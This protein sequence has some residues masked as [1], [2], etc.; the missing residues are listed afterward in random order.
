[1]LW[2]MRIAYLP[3]LASSSTGFVF[4]I[5]YCHCVVMKQN[6]D[7]FRFST[8]SFVVSTWNNSIIHTL[9]LFPWHNWRLLSPS[10]MFPPV[11]ILYICANFLPSTTMYT[12]VHMYGSWYCVQYFVQNV[13]RTRREI[14]FDVTLFGGDIR[15][16]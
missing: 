10:N 5:V 16:M 14:R 8:H 12:Y 9:F 11:N 6:D 4:C 13:A 2:M 1:M 7:C 3:A 15:T